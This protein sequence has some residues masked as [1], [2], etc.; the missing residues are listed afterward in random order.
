MRLECASMPTTGCNLPNR[1][2]S[3]GETPWT[4]QAHPAGMADALVA[5]SAKDEAAA[6][7][8]AKKVRKLKRS[9]GSSGTPA[10]A[11]VS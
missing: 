4:W 10:E 6:E 2:L 8:V 1:G 11:R 5:D 3:G 7:K 9:I